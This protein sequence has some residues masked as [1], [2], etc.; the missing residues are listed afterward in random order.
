MICEF[1]SI[2][3]LCVWQIPK[4]APDPLAKEREDV[5]KLVSDLIGGG[6]APASSSTKSPTPK[7][8]AAVGDSP[9]KEPQKQSTTPG[10]S[11]G[12]SRPVKHLVVD[13]LAPVNI[14]PRVS[15]Y[16]DLCPIIV[17]YS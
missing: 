7:A 13:Q 2:L 3:F 10:G 8:A 5:N 14:R 15:T 9:A 16:C 1:Q 4:A 11:V 6:A 12:R 17:M